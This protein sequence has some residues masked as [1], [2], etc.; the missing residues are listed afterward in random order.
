MSKPLPEYTPSTLEF[1][2]ENHSTGECTIAL[3]C[4]QV[5]RRI[6]MQTGPLAAACISRMSVG[7]TRSE[8]PHTLFFDLLSAVGATLS[9]VLLYDVDEQIHRF[10]A[11]V[12]IDFEEGPL[13][14]YARPSDAIAISLKFNVPVYVYRTVME[15]VLD[16]QELRKSPEPE[17]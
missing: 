10:R 5:D 11:K 7:E 8:V 16:Y 9:R 3:Y 2:F 17:G 15:R 14:V 6:V 13:T 1:L 12:Q 4:Y